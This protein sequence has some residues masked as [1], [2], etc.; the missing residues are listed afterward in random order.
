MKILFVC[1]AL[2]S[3]SALLTHLVR[4]RA[5]ARGWLDEANERSSHQ[6]AVPRG[7]GLAIDA[8]ILAVAGALCAAGAWS[9]PEA[10]AWLAGG[11]VLA[12]VGWLDDRYRLGVVSRLAAQVLAG[13]AA[14][15]AARGFPALPV[16]GGTFSFGVAAPLVGLIALLW[17]VN[18]FNFMDGIDGLAASQALFVA[19]AAAVLGAGS[20]ATTWMLW[21]TAAA[22]AGFLVFNWAPAR[23]FMGDVGSGFL[24]YVLALAMLLG[25]GARLSVWGWLILHSAFVVDATV[26][27]A[28]RLLRGERVYAAHRSHLYQRLSRRLGSHARVTLLYTLVNLGWLLPLTV[29]SVRYPA[30]GAPLAALA[31]AP[32]AGLALA[33]GAGRPGDLPTAV[34]D[35]NSR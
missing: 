26:T 25:A 33:F 35:A 15:Y 1:L 27:L 14:V 6:G 11:G 17:S 10:L 30:F 13:I 23:I 16:P 31:M 5:I 29:L 7:G 3:L 32:L 12:L 2:A 18:L 20:T 8:V 28:T 4:R 9:E 21:S 34:R 22:C 19:A 24:G